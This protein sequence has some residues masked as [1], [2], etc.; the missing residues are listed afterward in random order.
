MGASV[1]NYEHL[2]C[3]RKMRQTLDRFAL[4]EHFW[5]TVGRFVMKFGK[6]VAERMN[7]TFLCVF[8]G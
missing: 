6:H 4:S 8:C 2:K 5:I 7:I 3:V 1:A